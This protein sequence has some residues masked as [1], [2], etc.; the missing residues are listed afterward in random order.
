MPAEVPVADFFDFDV[1]SMA[2]D[3]SFRLE[4]KILRREGPY[5]IYEDRYGYTVKKLENRS[6]TVGFLS[7][8]TVDW[9]TWDKLKGRL[10]ISRDPAEPT[11]IDDKS[12]FAHFDP[13]PTW[14]EAAEKYRRLYASGRYLLF[15]GYGPWEST[16]RHRG[17]ENQLMDAAENPEWLK[18]MAETYQDLVIALLKECL[19]RGMR[20]DGFFMVEDLGYSKGMLVSPPCWRKVFKPSVA[21]LGQFLK[22]QNIDFWMHCCGNAEAVFEDLI[23]CG[24]QVMQPLQVSAGL[25]VRKLYP[26]YAPRLAFYGNISIGNILGDRAKLEEEVRTKIPLARQGGYVFHSD[27]SIPPDVP[28]ERYQWLLDFARRSF[29]E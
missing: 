20:P 11:R 5:I 10:S 7:H 9:Q 16:W 22:A 29:T 27:H 6:A 25:D 15:V 13:Y 28:F 26:K 12:Y 2:L 14:E 18:E 19:A 3:T 8:V 17:Y 21:R 4:Q 1:C 23:E 24:L